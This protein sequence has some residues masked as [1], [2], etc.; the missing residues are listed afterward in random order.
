M[1]QG[2]PGLR[3]KQSTTKDTKD[4][5]GKLA[6]KTF[7]FVHVLCGCRFLRSFSRCDPPVGAGIEQIERQSAAIEHLVVKFAEI[8]L[9]TQFALGTLAKFAELQLAKFVAEGLCGPGNVAVGF[10][11]DGGLVDSAVDKRP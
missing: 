4:H 6:E 1:G 3:Q 2:L 10:G 11:L 8:E 7:V 9:W 5:E